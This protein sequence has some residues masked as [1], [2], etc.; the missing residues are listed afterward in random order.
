[1]VESQGRLLL[2]VIWLTHW[3]P[4]RVL[5]G[6]EEEE[7]LLLLSLPWVW[8]LA[9]P[10]SVPATWRVWSWRHSGQGEGQQG[11]WPEG[12]WV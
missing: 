9:A 3:L 12:A 11:E 10:P 2:T 6:A 5:G 8:S 7:G 1:M 4:D